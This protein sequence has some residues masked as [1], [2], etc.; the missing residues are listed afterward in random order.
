[1]PPLVLMYLTCLGGMTVVL[2]FYLFELLTLRPFV[3][4]PQ[5]LAATVYRALVPSV[6]ATS[7]WNLSVGAVGVNRV[8]SF[9]KLLPIFSTALAAGVLGEQLHLYHLF[10]S[11][12]VCTG[13]MWVARK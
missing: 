11:A 1:M 2:P 12:L 10:A 3:L 5:V 4:Q 9:I 6:T 7:R 8:S 13:I